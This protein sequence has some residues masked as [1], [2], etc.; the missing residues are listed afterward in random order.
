MA[1]MA[2]AHRVENNRPPRLRGGLDL[3]AE[4]RRAEAAEIWTLRSVRAAEKRPRSAFFEGLRGHDVL[5]C[6]IAP[7]QHF[8]DSA[9]AVGE[10]TF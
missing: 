3:T 5:K 4:A 2:L 7:L 8:L 6:T 9:E 10:P 1:L